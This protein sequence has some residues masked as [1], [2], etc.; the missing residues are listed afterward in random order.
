[1]GVFHMG[2]FHMGVFHSKNVSVEHNYCYGHFSVEHFVATLSVCMCVCVCVCVCVR[3][4]ERETER[5]RQTETDRQ[6]DYAL[7]IVS[8]NKILPFINTLIISLINLETELSSSC[9][10][11][12]TLWRLKVSGWTALANRNVKN[13]DIPLRQ[14]ESSSQSVTEYPRAQELCE[15]RGGRPGLPISD[16]GA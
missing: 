4:R 7:R 3:E 13:N 8:T 9:S 14:V 6:T 2:V 15:S 10:A 5:Q 1:M 16:K 12:H 11:R